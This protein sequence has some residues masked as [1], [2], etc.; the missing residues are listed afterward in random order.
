MTLPA[1]VDNTRERSSSDAISKAGRHM[2]IAVTG[3]EAFVLVPTNP[4]RNL[5]NLVVLAAEFQ[6][7]EMTA[8]QTLRALKSDP[9]LRC[10][11]VIVLAGV[12]SPAHIRNLYEEQAACVIEF[13][14]GTCAF[15]QGLLD[16]VDLATFRTV[17]GSPGF[18]G[19]IS[20]DEK[21]NCMV[22]RKAYE[23]Q[24]CLLH[25]ADAEDPPLSP[26]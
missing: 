22:R 24:V 17:L 7:N 9:H 5:P 23:G 16:W 26:Q 10:V 15:Y 2:I 18:G 4:R 14:V 11:P 25:F 1:Q 19:Y 20:P 3:G 21:P 12:L 8:L 6:G 13:P